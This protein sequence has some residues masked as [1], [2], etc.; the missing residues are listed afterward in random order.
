MVSICFSTRLDISPNKQQTCCWSIV[1]WH[2]SCYSNI[3]WNHI[4]VWS[5]I[6]L[7]LVVFHTNHQTHALNLNIPE[8]IKILQLFTHL[9]C[10]RLAN[11]CWAVLLWLWKQVKCR[12]VVTGLYSFH[13]SL[14]IS[15]YIDVDLTLSKSISSCFWELFLFCTIYSINLSGRVRPEPATNPLG[16]HW[17]QR[18]AL[19]G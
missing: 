14:V 12:W 19:L 6:I 3:Y 17:R 7:S 13:S 2:Y 9:D 11:C 5:K 16:T 4:F 15:F 1:I 8:Y 10:W 18:S